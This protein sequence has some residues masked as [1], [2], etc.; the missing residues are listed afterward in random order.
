MI[1][2]KINVFVRK[3]DHWQQPIGQEYNV[4]EV[5]VQGSNNQEVIDNFYRK[6]KGC[7][8]SY[9]NE[10]SDIKWRNKLKDWYDS[11]DYKKR[12]F[13]LYYKNSIVD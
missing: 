3:S 8:A 11:E 4:R 9:Y 1:K 12:S 13:S 6:N 7:D 10:F 2:V 5:I